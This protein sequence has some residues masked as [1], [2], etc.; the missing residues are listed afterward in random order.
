MNRL[1]ATRGLALA[2]SHSVLAQSLDIGGVELKLG[3][4]SESALASLRAVY[5]V[6]YFDDLKLWSVARPEELRYEIG[7][8]Q[9]RAGVVSAISKSYVS[10]DGSVEFAQHFQAIKD[11]RARANS[12]CTTDLNER[13][14]YKSIVTACGRYLVIYQGSAKYATV[15]LSVVERR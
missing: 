8:L 6:R 5:N 11:G 10:S 15:S 14:N 3:Q 9:A 13:P 4:S 7:N 2:A 1:V 12:E